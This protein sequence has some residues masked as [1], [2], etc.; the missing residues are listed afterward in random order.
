MVLFVLPYDVI[1]DQCYCH[2][3]VFKSLKDISDKFVVL[4]SWLDTAFVRMRFTAA[5]NGDKYHN[6]T[7]F[8]SIN[9]LFGVK[10]H[11]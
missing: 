7:E 6:L 9:M 5:L 4:F 11:L 8:T 10:L 3:A 2:K 1:V